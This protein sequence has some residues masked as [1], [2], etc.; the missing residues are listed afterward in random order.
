MPLPIEPHPAEPLVDGG[1]GF[2]VED[3]QGQGCI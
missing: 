3:A 2:S 1:V